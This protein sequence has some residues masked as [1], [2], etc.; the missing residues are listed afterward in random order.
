MQ[1][2]H[3]R[4]YALGAFFGA[5]LLCGGLVS[6]Q[7]FAQTATSPNYQMTE[8][9]FGNTSSL[10]SCSDEYCATVSIGDDSAGSS[11]T[12]AEF[13][14]A[15]YSE[16]L[17]EMIV[18][19][20]DSNLGDL[21][22]EQTGTK[23]MKVKVRNYLSGGYMLQVIGDAPTFNGRPLN[24]LQ[25][26]TA[27]QTGLEQFGINVV[28]NTTP[29]IGANPIAQPSGQDDLTLV[30]DNYNTPNQFMYVSGQT[31]ALTETN[32]GGADFTITMIVNISNTTLAGNY[33]SDFSAV[34]M[35]FF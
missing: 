16:P 22:T 1:K 33:S 23:T 4:V 34:I 5:L 13:G 3:V 21:T 25:T 6:G 7:A 30:T 28:A 14:E 9:Q 15:N 8:S 29:S 17:L 26:P 20:G 2:Q 19:A 11:A 35:P 24:T 27:S 12:S 18:E 32:T 10:D 31:V